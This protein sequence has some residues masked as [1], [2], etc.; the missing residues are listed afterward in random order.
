MVK[1]IYQKRKERKE[2]KENN[3]NNWVNKIVIN[4]LITII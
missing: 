1:N 4:R 3:E 2:Q